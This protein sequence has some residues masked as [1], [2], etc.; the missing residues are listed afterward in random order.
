MQKNVCFVLITCPLSPAHYL[1]HLINIFL[2]S[3]HRYPNTLP[4]GTGDVNLISPESQVTSF[5]FR[6]PCFKD[7]ERCLWS[8]GPQ[9]WE[10]ESHIFLLSL[11]KG[12]ATRLSFFF[13][14]L[15]ISPCN[16]QNNLFNT[17]SKHT[18]WEKKQNIDGLYHN[19]GTWKRL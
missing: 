1:E 11:L 7:F 5:N 2:P 15:S 4:K 10:L 12:L 8:S 16:S 3:F 18:L 9:L 17:G 19:T 14:G 13:K 6:K